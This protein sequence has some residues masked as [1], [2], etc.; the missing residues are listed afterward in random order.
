MMAEQNVRH[1]Y[2]GQMD[3]AQHSFSQSV[4]PEYVTMDLNQQIA[5]ISLQVNYR[6]RAII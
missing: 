5:Y 1:P 4:E 3:G 2:K 6:W